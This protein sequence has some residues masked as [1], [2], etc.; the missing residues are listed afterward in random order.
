MAVSVLG[1]I[2]VGGI[3]TMEVDK[4]PA[5]DGGVAAT[6]G[7]LALAKDGSG[8]FYKFGNADTDWALSGVKLAMFYGLTP[9]TGNGG[10]NDYAATIAVKTAAGTG[11]V[12]FPRDGVS[13]GIVRNDGSSF[14][15][16]D[17]G[18][19]EV[20][21]NVQTAEPGQLQLELNGVAVDFST[22][23][24]ANPT[25][26]GHEINGTCIIQTTSV[27]SELAVINPVGNAT[28]LTVTTSDGVLTHAMAQRITICKR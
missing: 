12:P 19:Y 23:S 24:N 17:I 9:G 10:A 25:V 8:L 15:L 14:I 16:P 11:R 26:G 21:F 6:M 13:R 1:K 28:A 4:S 3:L 22:A 18:I 2:T 5:T 20:T 27:N 7:S